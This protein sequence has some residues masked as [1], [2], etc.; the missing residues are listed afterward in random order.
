MV[1]RITISIS[2]FS[3]ATFSSVSHALLLNGCSWSRNL[4]KLFLLMWWKDF[5]QRWQHCM[6]FFKMCKETTMAAFAFLSPP[7]ALAG[8]KLRTCQFQTKCFNHKSIIQ[9]HKATS[10]LYPK[11]VNFL[12]NEKLNGIFNLKTSHKFYTNITANHRINKS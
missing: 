9:I 1:I 3:F 7:T 5:R 4:Y 11:N 6:A 12:I 8:L 2:Y 10:A